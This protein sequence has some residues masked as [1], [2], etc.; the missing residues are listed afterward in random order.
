MSV[1]ENRQCSRSI[2]CDICD[3]YN[4]ND[5]CDICDFRPFLTF[6]T[7]MILMIIMIFTDLG[8]YIMRKLLA[9]TSS[10]T[11]ILSFMCDLTKTL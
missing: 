2:I 7:F 3:I 6:M 9:A 4:I 1:N 10:A 8:S 5:I 11:L